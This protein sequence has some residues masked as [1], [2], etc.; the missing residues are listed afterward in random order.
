MVNAYHKEEKKA[1]KQEIDEIKSGVSNL[2][3]EVTEFE[4][5]MDD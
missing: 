1:L 3:T 5:N 4:K 2:F